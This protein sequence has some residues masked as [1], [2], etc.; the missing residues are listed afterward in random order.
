MQMDV[1]TEPHTEPR[2]LPKKLL[3]RGGLAVLALAAVYFLVFAR[4]SADS[5]ARG[6]PPG[7]GGMGGFGAPALV[8]AAPVG[9][10]AFQLWAEFV[11]TLRARAQADLYAKTSG[12]VVEVLADTGDRVRA[13]QLLARID[14]AEQRERFDQ[15]QAAVAMAE[16]T[17][18]QRRAEHEIARTTAAR[19]ESLF[20]QQLVA[21]QQHE[22]SQAE[23]KGAEAQVAV[24]RAAVAQA[25]AN[26]AA[27]QVEIEK[28]RIVA[29]FD[30]WVGK[31]HLDLGAF[32]A[33]NQ[34]VF[35]VVDLS[36][37]KTTVPLTEK[38]AGQ[39]RV[40]QPAVVTVEAVPGTEFE[41]RVARLSSLFDP[42]TNTTEAE[43][44]ISNPDGRLKPGMFATV[45]IALAT[46][47]DALLVPRTAVLQGEIGAYVFVV[48]PAP[49]EPA[50]AGEG[51]GG[52]E[53]AAPGAPEDTAQAPF[54]VKRVPVQ[55]LGTGAG[56]ERHLAAVAGRLTPGQKV[57]VL[58]HEELRDG[59]EVRVTERRSG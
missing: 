40:G 16:A 34:P 2:A 26:L 52:P 32:A 9:R 45:A 15:L 58:G 31:R 29:P 17:L 19:T 23:L 42:R 41:A 30:G 56:A 11:G 36:T 27:G 8:E 48:A 47:P 4:D 57:V 1:T 18:A 7:M 33:G 3:V 53:A 22:A 12:Q 46:A 28:T 51:E 44:E 54:V 38:D 5:G 39:V 25:R 49:A 10:G 59:A 24:A 21:L 50:E 6:G 55:K 14:A 20:A 37:I 35:T 13:G 43:V